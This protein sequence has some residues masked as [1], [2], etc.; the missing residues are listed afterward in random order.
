MTSSQRFRHVHTTAG[1]FVLIVV[2]LLVAGIIV[3]GR[4]H[5]WFSPMGK[6][7]LQFP[8]EGSLGLREGADVLILGTVVGSVR[9]DRS[10][11]GIR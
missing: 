5:R 11:Q 2:G 10:R 7:T 1:T 3:T 6:V 4:S 9:H 8:R